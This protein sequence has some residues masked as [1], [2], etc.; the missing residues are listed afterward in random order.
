VNHR[1]SGLEHTLFSEYPF[2]ESDP[3]HDE[4]GEKNIWPDATGLNYV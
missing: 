3:Q 4:M 1:L 2:W